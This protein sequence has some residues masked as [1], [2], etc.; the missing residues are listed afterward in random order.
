MKLL[1]TCL[2][3]NPEIKSEL[4]EIKKRIDE[5][6]FNDEKRHLADVGLILKFISD[7]LS[8]ISEKVFYLHKDQKISSSENES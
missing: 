6:V 5:V 1:W 7:D 2:K 3:N 4:N 8:K